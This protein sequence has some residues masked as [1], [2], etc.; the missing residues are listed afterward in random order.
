[1][2][3]EFSQQADIAGIGIATCGM[4]NNDGKIVGSAENIEGW[5]DTELKQLIE[6]GTGLP[7][8]VENDANVSA[9]GEYRA[10][11]LSTK[12]SVVVVTLGT[13]IGGG[14]IVDGKIWRGAHYA[15]GEVGHFK[16]GM[17]RHRLCTC[18]LWDCFE[19]YGSGRGLVA[20][21]EDILLGMHDEHSTLWA[22]H[23][24]LTTQLVIKAAGEKDKAAVESMHRWH[25][26]LSQ[27]ISI[28]AQMVDPELFILTG[29][30]SPF[31]DYPLLNKLTNER[32]VIGLAGNIK[33]N[34]SLLGENP[35]LI[36]AG[37][38][39]LDKLA[40]NLP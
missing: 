35:G 6:L 33:I 25:V 11:S 13:G 36:G 19:A 8:E 28:A 37:Q 31:V 1:L 2:V 22:H 9:Y 15:A 10:Y 30:L 24:D 29:G 23:G 21:A 26:H 38:L 5:Q 4:V 27:G 20:T 3:K 7:V 14:I 18:G 16:I 34:P 17:G 12:S 40:V 39:L 32:A